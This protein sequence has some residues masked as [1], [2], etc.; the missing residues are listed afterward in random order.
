M[1]TPDRGGDGGGGWEEWQGKE[2]MEGK[3][4]A[5]HDAAVSLADR[6]PAL[7]R[8]LVDLD[9]LL[10]PDPQ[11]SGLRFQQ[12]H[13][14]PQL[15]SPVPLCHLGRHRHVLLAGILHR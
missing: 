4:A 11:E 7:H 1:A 13:V 10:S 9:P 3:G 6:V 2:E 14:Q 5:V 15:R 8:R 12:V